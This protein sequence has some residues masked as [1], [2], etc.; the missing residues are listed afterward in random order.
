MKIGKRI[1]KFKFCLDNRG[2]LLWEIKGKGK[3]QFFIMNILENN[4]K[5]N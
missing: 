4:K 1:N 3:V 5:K 2:N